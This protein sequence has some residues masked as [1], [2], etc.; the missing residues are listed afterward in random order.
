MMELTS[1]VAV[2]RGFDRSSRARR[3]LR[4]EIRRRAARRGSSGVREFVTEV[5][6]GDSE[7]VLLPRSAEPVLA[8]GLA[9]VEPA[10]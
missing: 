6:F 7:A 1:G 5:L 10:G 4:L 3:P 9:V 8:D 2:R